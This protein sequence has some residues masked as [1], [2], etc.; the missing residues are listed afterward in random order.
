LQNSRRHKA[1]PFLKGVWLLVAGV[2][3]LG[4]TA[5]K[6]ESYI[7]VWEKGVVYYHFSIREH[8][9]A[10]QAGID[11]A[12]LRRVSS[13]PQARGTLPQADGFIPDRNQSS[14]LRPWLIRAVNRMEANRNAPAASPQGVPGLGQLRLGK[15]NE[16]QG[17]NCSPPPENMWAG[18][19]SLGRLLAKFGCRSPLV[20][21]APHPEAQRLDRQPDLPPIRE[22]QALVREVC[23]NFLK[24]AQE[25]RL[26]LG[27]GQPGAERLAES[28]HP[29]YC[30]PVAAPFSFR[31]TWGDWRSGG[32]THR[33][34]DI[35]AWEGTP[36]YAITAGVIHQLATWDGAGISLLLAGQDGHGYGYMHLLGYAEGI[37]EGKPVKKGE[38][39]A[40]VGHTGIKQDGPHLHLQVYADHRFDRAE[41]LDPY[42]LLVQLCNGQGVTDLSHPN[43]ARRRI[44]A[45]E[46]MPYGTVKL[47]GSG[48]RIYQVNR[49]TVPAAPTWVINRY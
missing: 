29:F 26:Q 30:F 45:A 42:A 18:S 5:V 17:V 15:A 38:L 16:G 31:D 33:A 1:L 28:N 40:Y 32:R 13:D 7:R 46:V 21:T 8:P 24:D 37:V 10:G 36:V 22:I 3:L 14:N 39:I 9:R 12:A 20:S 6:A 2:L 44:P 48:P 49:P 23:R 43:L 4:H 27:Q 34:V 47:S 41:L 35:I 25:P 19:R 11:P